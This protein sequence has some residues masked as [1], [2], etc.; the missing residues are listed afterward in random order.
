MATRVQAV[1]TWVTQFKKALILLPYITAFKG[2]IGC[3]QMAQLSE[4]SLKLKIIL[5]QGDKEE[6]KRKK[7]IIFS[8]MYAAMFVPSCVV[9]GVSEFQLMDAFN[10]LNLTDLFT[11]YFIFYD[12]YV[13]GLQTFGILAGSYFLMIFIAMLLMFKELFRLINN[14][15]EL[16]EKL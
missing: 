15:G 5:E 7:K 16:N 6:L 12:K 4:L 2:C 13:R 3:V 8:C 1:E 9:I 11:S 10:A 14:P